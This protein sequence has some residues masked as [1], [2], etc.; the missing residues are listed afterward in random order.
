M[1]S[2][3]VRDNFFEDW[4]Y[5]GH[6]K[7]W[8]YGPGAPPRWIQFNNNGQELD[9][10]APTPPITLVDA[11]EA[12]PLVLAKAGCW[13]RDRM[14]KRTIDDV[15]NQTGAWGR[16][17][18]LEPTD[19]WFLEGLATGKAPPD[20]DNDGIPDAWEAAHGLDANNQAD[21]GKT[22]PAGASKDIRHQGYSFIEFYLNELADSLMP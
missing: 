3:Y 16:S 14:T 15:K 10:P 4:G 1:M 7:N 13:P 5:Q 12:Y 20:G 2:Y 9:A 22:V 8:K 17:G 18:P 11:K 6:P 21:G 19:E